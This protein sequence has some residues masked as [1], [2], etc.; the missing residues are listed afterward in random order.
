M[1]DDSFIAGNTLW[2]TPHMKMHGY[3]NKGVTEKVFRKSL[4]LKGAILFVL[5]KTKLRAVLPGRKAG[6]LRLRSG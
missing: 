3:Q 1:S 6:A 4:N 5:E 2:N